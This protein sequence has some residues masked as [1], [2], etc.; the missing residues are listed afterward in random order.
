MI[1]EIA[2]KQL[3]FKARMGLWILIVSVV[4]VGS[5]LALRSTHVLIRLNDM[6]GGMI[7]SDIYAVDLLYAPLSGFES[8]A[9]SVWRH[10]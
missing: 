3:G 5:Y 4:Y 1:E 2:S 7:T 6:E 9:R 8:T 10:R